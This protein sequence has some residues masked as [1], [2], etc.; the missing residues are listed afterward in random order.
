MR[1]CTNIS[2]KINGMENSFPGVPENLKG[3]LCRSSLFQCL[4]NTTWKTK[5]N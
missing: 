3:K 1:D 4:S 2:N 5:L